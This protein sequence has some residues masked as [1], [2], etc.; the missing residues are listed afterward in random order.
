[1]AIVEADQAARKRRPGEDLS[2]FMSSSRRWSFHVDLDKAG[3]FFHQMIKGDR[4]D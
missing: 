3:E 2:T 4:H 1:M